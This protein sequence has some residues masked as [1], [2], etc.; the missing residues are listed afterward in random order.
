[1]RPRA[2]PR[3]QEPIAGR[4][5][6]AL[7][8]GLINWYPARESD[9]AVSTDSD[10]HSD[11]DPAAAGEDDLVGRFESSMKE[12][13]DIV[14]RIEHGEL[15]LEESLRLFERGTALAQQ[16]RRTLETAELRVRKLIGDGAGEVP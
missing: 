5:M 7:A 1:M 4:I 8:A 14:A 10:S 6:H 9:M 15:R 16:C 2:R 13:E 12:L 3:A 11:S